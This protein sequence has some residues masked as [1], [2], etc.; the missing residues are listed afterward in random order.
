MRKPIKT[1]RT[2]PLRFCLYRRVSSQG[3]VDRDLSLPEQRA[4][5]LAYVERVNGTVTAEYED[6]GVSASRK[7]IDDRVHFQE[8]IAA[9]KR[10][11]FDII[12]IHK[13]DRVFR[14]KDEAS[15]YRILSQKI[16]LRWASVTEDFFGSPEPHDKLLTGIMESINEFYTDNMSVEVKKGIRSA[17][18][19]KGR[20]H[21]PPPYGYRYADLS[22]RASGWS[23]DEVDGERVRYIFSYMSTQMPT[24]IA[25]CRHLNDMGWPASSDPERGLR[26]RGLPTWNR[27]AGGGWNTVTL[28]RLLRSRVYV[29]DILSEGVWL[30]G[31]QPPLVD[32]ELAG[33]VIALIDGR[34]PGRSENTVALF[35]AGMLR[36]PV[37]AKAGHDSPLYVHT[38][39][40]RTTAK[41]PG[42]FGP[43]TSY[44]CGKRITDNQVKKL[45][46]EFPEW[47]CPGF[48]ISDSKIT[49]LVLAFLRGVLSHSSSASTDVLSA[50]EVPRVASALR[51]NLAKFPRQRRRYLELF[52][53][54]GITKEQYRV[55]IEQLDRRE[56]EI[57][58]AID[59]EE[60]KPHIAH[61]RSTSIGLVLLRLLQNEELTP[62][63]KRDRIRED[64]RCFIPTADKKKIYIAAQR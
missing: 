54:D 52:V 18:I 1:E 30:P 23:I 17:A 21:G 14:N 49:R 6:G 34:S 48:S 58:A 61:P 60:A 64:I 31:H 63:Q 47:E 51:D 12:L 10:G 5:Q 2:G 57:K 39:P 20:Q 32:R 35:G 13:S 36:C 7:S 11:E 42:T 45:Q 37:C 15:T 9:A 4:Q 25:M 38:I 22:H 43:Y 24:L 27:V 55:E 16:G 33:K 8:M 56:Q 46:G 3:Q 19:S 59:R 40:R 53:D 28:A 44:H 29:G 41:H 62:Q 26:E 50:V